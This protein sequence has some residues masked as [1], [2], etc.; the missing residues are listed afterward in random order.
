MPISLLNERAVKVK[1]RKPHK[2]VNINLGIVEIDNFELNRLV[3][4]SDVDLIEAV[5][6]T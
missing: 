5:F 3:C 4:H 6:A 2:L 1:A